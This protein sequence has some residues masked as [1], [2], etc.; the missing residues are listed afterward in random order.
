MSDWEEF[1]KLQGS[2]P[3]LP[4]AVAYFCTEVIFLE[5]SRIVRRFHTLDQVCADSTI[6]WR[7]KEGFPALLEME[8]KYF[9]LW[10]QNNVP[11]TTLTGQANF[12]LNILRND[13][14][15]GGYQSWKETARRTPV[16]LKEIQ[17]RLGIYND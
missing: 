13:P 17:K 12:Y 8:E 7:H 4:K 16:D 9:E 11:L 1:V 14:G 15:T 6:L 2:V 3:K 10:S 5:G